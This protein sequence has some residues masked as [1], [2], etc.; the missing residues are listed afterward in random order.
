MLKSNYILVLY[1]TKF[2][3]FVNNQVKTIHKKTIK[4]NNLILILKLRFALH[5]LILQKQKTCYFLSLVINM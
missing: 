2:L 1:I 5:F 3:V 4:S